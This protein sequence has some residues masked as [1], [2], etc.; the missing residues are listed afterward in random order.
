[1]CVTRAKSQNYI[2]EAEG[3][4]VGYRYYETRY[5]DAVNGVGNAASPVGA[6]ASSTEWNYDNEV[7]IRLWLWPEL[8]HL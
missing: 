5:A 1:M 3:I 7:T 6:Y 8:H 2:I 4:Y